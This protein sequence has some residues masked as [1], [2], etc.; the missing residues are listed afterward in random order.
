M[1]DAAVRYAKA[2]LELCKDASSTK[3]V[4]TQLNQMLEIW[5]A[6]PELRGYHEHP[7]HTVD[8]RRRQTAALADRL[9]FDTFIKNFLLLLSD[10]KRVSELPKV[11]RAFTEIADK[12]EGHIKA[13]VI[14]SEVLSPAY[15]EE[16]KRALEKVTQQQVTLVTR[17]DPTLIGG[18]IAKVGDRI[19][20]GSVRGQLNGLRSALST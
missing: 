5:N 14:S 11:V 19:F 12:R 15:L 1:A 13:E 9:G 20:D 3:H 18:I 7:G 2:L 8:E 10:R 4:K 17:Q 6:H 16:V